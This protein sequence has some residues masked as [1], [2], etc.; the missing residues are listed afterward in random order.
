MSDETYRVR[1]ESMQFA[2]AHFATFGGACE[3][4]HGHS[5][6]V[7]AEV[8][9]TLSEDRWVVDFIALKSMIRGLTRELDHRFML[10][11]QSNVLKIEETDAAWHVTTPAKIEYLLPKP[12]VAALPIDNTTAELLSQWL[13]GRVWEQL[14]GRFANVQSLTVEVSEGPGQRASYRRQIK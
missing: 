8:E 1:V 4:L 2:A 5:Y 6:E 3:P 13:S 9:G 10:Q 12:D 11:C 7:A 14:Q